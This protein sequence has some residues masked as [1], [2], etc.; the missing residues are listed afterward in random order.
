MSVLCFGKAENIRN[1]IALGVFGSE[2]TFGTC[3]SPWGPACSSMI[4][5]ASGLAENAPKGALIVGPC[6]PTVNEWLPPDLMTLSIPI[7]TAE[8][9]ANDVEASFLGKRPKVAFP[10]KRLP[11]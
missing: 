9:M 10:E 3:I 1:L 11:D 5:Y 6:D 4:T 8:R 2:D 7:A